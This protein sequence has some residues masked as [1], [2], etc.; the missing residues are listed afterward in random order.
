MKLMATATKFIVLGVAALAIS[1]CTGGAEGPATDNVQET[2][3]G[4]DSTT[5]APSDTTSGSTMGTDSVQEPAATPQ[6]Q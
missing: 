3:E 4:M 6:Q 2:Q 5:G 1:G